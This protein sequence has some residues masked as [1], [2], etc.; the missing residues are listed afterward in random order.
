[1]WITNGTIADVAVI[2]AK[3]ADDPTDRGGHGARIRGPDRPPG[4]A[5]REVTAKLSL[6]ASAT[7]EIV[8]QGRVSSPP[9]VDTARASP[10]FAVRCPA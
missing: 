9:D 7:A 2:W 3:V 4:F 1:M 10:D 6:R 8:L 5:A